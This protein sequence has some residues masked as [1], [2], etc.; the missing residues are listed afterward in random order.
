MDIEQKEEEGVCIIQPCGRFDASNMM[1][2]TEKMDQILDGCA[3]K[4]LIDLSE[5]EYLSSSCLGMLIEIQK[6]AINKGIHIALC[7][8]NQNILELLHVVQ[9]DTLFEIYNSKAE[10][11]EEMHESIS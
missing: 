2:F 1:L 8:P 10:A 4:M 7:S 3:K 5:L 11:I 6:K 9:L